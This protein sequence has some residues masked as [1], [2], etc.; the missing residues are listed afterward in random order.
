MKAYL[1]ICNHILETGKWSENRTG[2]KVIRVAAGEIFVHD[3]D[4]GFPLITTKKMGLTNI[5]TELEFFIKGITDKR[6][7]QDRGCNIWNKWASKPKWEPVYNLTIKEFPETFGREPTEGEKKEIENR[8]IDNERDLGPVYGFQ[9]RHFGGE[10]QFD[11]AHIA[12]DP[13][14]NFNHEKPGFDQIA[15]ILRVLRLPT[16]IRVKDD[17]A[18]RMVVSA[19]NP[20]EES[21]MGLPPCHFAYNLLLDNDRLNL[22]WTQRSCDMFLGVPYNIASYALLLM[23]Y[24]KEAGLKPGILKGELHDAHIYEN[25]IPQMREQIKRTP[26]QLPT[27]EIPDENWKGMLAWNAANGFKLQNYKHHDKLYGAVAR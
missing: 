17:K 20:L 13:T 11:T 7:L 3:M 15:D 27:V 21:K 12:K 26:Y 4:M 19:W 23:L 25:H 5:A 2:E 6:W 1:D 18:R 24:A 10:Y 22:T 9:W 14:D 16:D 8:C